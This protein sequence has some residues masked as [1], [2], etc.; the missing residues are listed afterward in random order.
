MAP[1]EIERAVREHEGH[2][3]ARVVRRA[4]DSL[5]TREGT[6][7]PLA[8]AGMVLAA[9]LALGGAATAQSGPSSSKAVLKGIVL[10]PDRSGPAMGVSVSLFS[11]D[12]TIAE[13]KTDAQGRFLLEADPGK[14]DIFVWREVFARER[15]P[16]ASLHVGEQI[17][18][19]VAL[20]EI[21]RDDEVTVTVGEVVARYT[22]SYFFR[23]PLIYLKSLRHNS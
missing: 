8:A 17:L 21:V 3:C 20:R 23:H 14:Y 1:G 6:A 18:S 19:P 11:R 9:S 12:G 5:V 4:D 22:F 7:Q 10:L 15:I 16:G 2:L 13:A